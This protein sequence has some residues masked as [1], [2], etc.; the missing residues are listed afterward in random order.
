MKRNKS[1]PNQAPT[2]VSSIREEHSS[3]ITLI[4][5]LQSGTLSPTALTH[6]TRRACVEHLTA[7]GYSVA[8]VAEFL[9][10]STRTVSRDLALIREVNAIE[11]DPALGGQFV[12]ELMAQARQSIARLRR[13]TRERDCPHATRVEAERSAW[14]IIRELGEILQRLGYLPTA[15]QEIHADLTHRLEA[16]PS[17]EELQGQF[18]T[19]QRV[20]REVK[21]DDVAKAL[22][23]PIQADLARS[24]A[25]EKI[26][27]LG[28]AVSVSSPVTEASREEMPD[29][30]APQA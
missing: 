28:Q 20:L 7:E 18:E 23:A 22:L 15:A 14:T 19:M 6:E 5:E 29:A 26:R 30:N 1:K 3:P 4:R 27:A 11:Q 13:I 25:S 10:V 17:L 9:K 24:S 21:G 12:G 16:P 2:E 8:E